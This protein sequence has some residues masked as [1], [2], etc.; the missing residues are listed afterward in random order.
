MRQLIAD[1][2]FT[3]IQRAQA[4]LTRLFEEARKSMSFYRVMKNDKPL[5]V[6]VPNE[7]WEDFVEDMEALASPNFQRRIAESRREKKG[8]TLDEVKKKL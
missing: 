2:K 1:E 5:G 4:G 3:N 7:M 6:L 8:Y